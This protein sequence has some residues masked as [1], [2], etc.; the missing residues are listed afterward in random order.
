MAAEEH[1]IRAAVPAPA[2]VSSIADTGLSAADVAVRVDAGQTNAF[3]QASSR[4]IW[5][6]IRA[7]TLTLFNGIIAGCFLVLLLDR[8]STRLNSSHRTVSRM[9]SS[10]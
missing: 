5:S 8:K 10:A 7:N 4:S 9:P 1:S 3:V 2:S 6:I